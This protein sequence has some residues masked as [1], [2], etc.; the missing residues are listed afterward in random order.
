MTVRN[1]IEKRR[2][3]FPFE[4]AWRDAFDQPETTGVWFIWGKSGNGKTSF[5]LRLCKELA[6]W[7][8]V[9]YDS[10]EEGDSLTFVKALQ[11]EGLAD[12]GSQFLLLP[13]ESMDDL[14]Y[15]LSQRKSPDVVVI[16]SFQYT[17][18]NHKEALDFCDR[19]RDKLIIFISQAE[20]SKPSGR[21]AQSLL[22]DAHQKIR[23]EGYRAFSLGRYKGNSEYY[24]IWSE[25][26]R[27][28][29]GEE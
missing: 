29:W 5:A 21:S 1:A 28:Y 12:C 26:A 17:R 18:M 22:F 10:L 24:E 3:V 4:G 27:L 8:R 23:V 25:R 7:R 15:R 20:G 9:V 14:D 13:C 2:T 6:R 16:D 11:R 19:H